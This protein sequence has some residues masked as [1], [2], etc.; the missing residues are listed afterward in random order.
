MVSI[1]FVAITLALVWVGLTGKVTLDSLLVGYVVGIIVLLLL[2]AMGITFT[3]SASARRP[4]AMVQ[5]VAALL[6]SSITS[7]L[8]VARLVLSPKIELKTGIIAL[9]TGDLSESQMLSALSAHAINM[10]PGEL[11][12]DLEDGGVLYIHCI[13]VVA[14]RANIEREQEERLKILKDL[15]GD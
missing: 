13:D 10:T 5:Y 8:K 4:I 6:W 2:R 15:I 1:F 7:S 14:S 12:I 9:N 11:V 3:T